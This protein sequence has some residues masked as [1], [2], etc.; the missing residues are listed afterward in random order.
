[1]P[2]NQFDLYMDKKL[3]Q[4][5]NDYFNE[6]N[7]DSVHNEKKEQIINLSSEIMYISFTSIRTL[8]WQL[9]KSEDNILKELMVQII[10]EL[11]DCCHNLP[12]YTNL[13]RK[14]EGHMH[15]GSD[16]ARAVSTFCTIKKISSE[17]Q[18]RFDLYLNNLIE[19]LPELEFI[20]A[21]TQF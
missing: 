21:N 17:F 20:E 18:L 9:D 19:K 5:I 11:S 10:R 4:K 1:M 16:L 15:L 14:G 7:L 8:S 12:L 6:L 13:L 3:N 2:K